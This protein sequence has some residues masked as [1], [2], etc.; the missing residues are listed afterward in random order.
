[1]VSSIVLILVLPVLLGPLL[2][3][4]VHV[5][6]AVAEHVLD[7]PRQEAE[8]HSQEVYHIDIFNIVRV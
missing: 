1:V 7:M 8:E 2:V 5:G 6:L 4:L 3:G